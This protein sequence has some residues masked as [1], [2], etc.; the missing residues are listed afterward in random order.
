MGWLSTLAKGRANEV[1]EILGPLIK[2]G[3]KPSKSMSGAIIVVA[4]N[5]T[6]VLFQATANYDGDD[7]HVEMDLLSKLF[8][9]TKNVLDAPF[10]LPANC[11]VYLYVYNSPCKKCAVKL[12][13]ALK[14]SWRKGKNGT[15]TWKVG[16]S[17]W[18]TGGG[19]DR[20][21]NSMAASQDYGN[22]LAAAGWSIKKV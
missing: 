6:D 9:W 5:G 15:V 21:F 13:Q 1:H 8:D 22:T 11:K 18:Y 3:L 10:F 19:S 20:Y 4:A 14:W 2:L 7:Y 17:Q 12:A 16:F